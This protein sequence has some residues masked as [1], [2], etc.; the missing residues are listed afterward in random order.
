MPSTL[1]TFPSLTATF[2]TSD[3]ATFTVRN[4][5]RL[6][7]FPAGVDRSAYFTGVLPE[8]YG[9]A[10]L[11][12][13]I[14]WIA[15]SATAGD[16]VWGVAFERHGQVLDLDTDSFATE[17]TTTSTAQSTN[18][19]KRVA[20]ITFTNTEIDGLLAGEQYRIRV[21][22]VG[23]NGS[24]TM[25]G[26]AQVAIVTI[27]Q[28]L[29]LFQIPRGY[30]SGGLL[31]WA[32]ASTVTVGESGEVSLMA[33]DGA[34]AWIEF[35]G[36]LTADIT[37]SGAGGLDTGSEAS[38]TWYAVWVIDD[39]S[40]TNSPAAMF[41][42]SFTSPTM[43]SGYDLKRRV[44]T[45]RNNT[46][47]NIIDFVQAHSGSCRRFNWRDTFANRTLL[48]G[49]TA[50]TPTSV[51]LSTYVP[52][53]TQIAD[54]AIFNNSTVRTMRAYTNTT[55]P[56]ILQLGPSSEYL[57][58][59]PTTSSQTVAYDNDSGGGDANIAVYGWQEEV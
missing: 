28:V 10:G 5:H 49:G 16:V 32:S 19:V 21:R 56:I 57:A 33:D 9:G 6:L 1:Q 35:T 34:S 59:F 40:G 58:L 4:T 30:I 47:S 11:T 41:S 46:S 44:G 43:P 39:S 20:E 8:A 14:E 2:P 29:D 7:A 53:S 17:K 48:S 22:R 52:P 26:D 25:S 31:A 23:T 13:G 37:A 24:D 12:V 54:L 38:S 51:D 15:A 3:A 36:T 27:S 18:G 50:T 55:D 42:T 45:V